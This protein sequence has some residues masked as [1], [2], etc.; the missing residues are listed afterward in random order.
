MT[1]W[2]TISHSL[3]A[4]DTV[5]L[6]E[7][8]L[9]SFGCFT[10]ILMVAWASHHFLTGPGFTIMIASMGA[11][12]ILLFAVPHSPFSLPWSIIG[13]QVIS[14]LIGISCLKFIPNGILALAVAVALATFVMHLLRC[15]HPPGGATAA[16]AVL[17]GDQMLHLGYQ[18]AFTPVAINSVILLCMALVLNNLLPRRYYPAAIKHLKEEPA[19]EQENNFTA[20][21]QL[22]EQDLESALKQLNRVVDVDNED[23]VQIYELAVQHAQKP[24]LESNDIQLGHFYSNGKFGEEWSVRQVVDQPATHSVKKPTDRIAY[25]V[26][27]G[28]NR[29]TKNF[30]K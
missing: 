22:S 14:A 29:R 23:L 12:A 30:L 3:I 8:V 15:L 18:F 10:A 17:G 5:S 1:F 7:K 6:G 21:S 13:G 28:K 24:T 11:S 2:E 4:R 26:I 25:R 9:A 27:A 19:L 20:G 16:A